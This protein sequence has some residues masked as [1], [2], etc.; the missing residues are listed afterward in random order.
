MRLCAGRLAIRVSVGLAAEREKEIVVD[1][2]SMGSHSLTS[3]K[4]LQTLVAVALVSLLWL[5]FLV[6]VADADAATSHYTTVDVTISKI[7][8]QSHL[9]RSKSNRYRDHRPSV[10]PIGALECGP[11]T[12]TTTCL[13]DRRIRS[14]ENQ[15]QNRWSVESDS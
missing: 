15:D 13:P 2:L 11:T 14:Y 3:L 8:H 5:L 10:D 1:L 6:S 12:T 4:M 9:H 7:S